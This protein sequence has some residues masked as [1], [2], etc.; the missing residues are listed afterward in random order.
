MLGAGRGSVIELI[1][2]GWDAKE[3]LDALAT[4]VEAGFGEQ[5]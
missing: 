3:A 1:A 2:D 4:L 5:D